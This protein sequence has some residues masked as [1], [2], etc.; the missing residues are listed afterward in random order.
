M[1]LY[2]GLYRQWNMWEKFDRLCEAIAPPTDAT[3]RKSFSESVAWF[4]L[5]SFATTAT[6]D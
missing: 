3:T 5:N 1:R 2:E 6:Q 4:G